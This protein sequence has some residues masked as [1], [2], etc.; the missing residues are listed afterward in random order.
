MNYAWKEREKYEKLFP[1]LYSC[2]NKKKKFFIERVHDV[3]R[4]VETVDEEERKMNKGWK[5]KFKV[6]K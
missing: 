5:L 3:E 4:K 2:N 6:K 1:F